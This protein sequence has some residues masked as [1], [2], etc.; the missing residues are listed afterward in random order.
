LVSVEEYC[1]LNNL[2]SLTCLGLHMDF[3]RLFVEFYLSRWLRN[4]YIQF[5]LCQLKEGRD[6][7]LEVAVLGLV[8]S[9]H[10]VNWGEERH[11]V[12]V[13]S[14]VNLGVE[15]NHEFH[16]S[17]LDDF[18]A[19]SRQMRVGDFSESLELEQQ[20]NALAS[21]KKNSVR[22]GNRTSVVKASYLALVSPVL[23]LMLGVDKCDFF[24]F[25]EIL[26]RVLDGDGVHLLFICL[27]LKMHRHER[28]ITRSHCNLL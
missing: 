11:H 2:H 3:R 21:V 12:A 20:L 15:S 27:V 7:H 24:T 22:R 23:K 13:E 28:D 14:R 17:L 19:S 26:V 18:A 25:E 6:P 5:L 16:I 1:Q 9:E 10:M 4:H 8:V